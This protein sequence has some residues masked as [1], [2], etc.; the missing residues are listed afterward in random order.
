[1]KE[2]RDS[3]VNQNEKYFCLGEVSIHGQS[4]LSHRMALYVVYIQNLILYEPK[5]HR[6]VSGILPIHSR[7]LTQMTK[8][9]N[10]L[11]VLSSQIVVNE[12]VKNRTVTQFCSHHLNI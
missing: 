6:E 12:R 10:V 11:Y 1:M 2:F 8:I 7:K 9:G 3:I 4:P 5:T